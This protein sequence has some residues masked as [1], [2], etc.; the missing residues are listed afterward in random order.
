[1]D[2]LPLLSCL[3]ATPRG[4]GGPQHGTAAK[5]TPYFW[6]EDHAVPK[7]LCS[8]REAVLLGT[9]QGSCKLPERWARDLWGRLKN[10]LAFPMKSRPSSEAHL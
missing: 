4:A 6:P 2:T 5:E 10:L 9:S 3:H 8:F 7:H 1:M